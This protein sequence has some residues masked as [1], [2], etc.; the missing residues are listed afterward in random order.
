MKSTLKSRLT[1]LTLSC[2]CFLSACSTTGTTGTTAA[3]S[4]RST[5]SAAVSGKAVA[6]SSKRAIVQPTKPDDGALTSTNPMKGTNK[7]KQ[8]NCLTKEIKSESL[9]ELELS[10][11]GVTGNV[12]DPA[13]VALDMEATSSTG[14]KLTIPGFYYVP[15]SWTSDGHLGSQSGE[16]TWRLRFT[17]TLE[18]TWD[19]KI[20]LSLNGSVVDT[21][22]GYVNVA[23]S[24]DTRGVLKVEPAR[25]QNF[26][27]QDGESYVPIGENIGWA[28]PVND[29]SASAT[30]FNNILGKIADNGGNFARILLVNWNLAL[31]SG[32]TPPDD[33]SRGMGNAM[34]LDKIV[35]YL[36]QRN[37]YVSFCIYQHDQFHAEDN[38][39]RGNAFNAANNGY[40]TNPGDFFTNDRAKKDAKIYIRYIVARYGYSSN[41][42]TWELF[43]EIDG[44]DGAEA[45]ETTW[46]VEMTQYL[47]SIDSYKHLVSCSSAN[48]P[49]S[50]P[51]NSV[52][53]FIQYHR[54]NYGD[55]KNLADLQKKTWL[56]QQRPL[57]LGEVGI[58]TDGVNSLDKDLVN[59]HQQNWIGVMGGGAGACVNWFWEQLEE[60][61]GYKDYKPLSQFAARIPWTDPKMVMVDTANASPDNTQVQVLGYRGSGYA[62]LWVFDSKYTHTNKMVTDFPGVS[63]S[64][65]MDNGDYTVDWVDPWT[66]NSLGKSSVT[67]SDK[68]ANIKTPGWSKDIAVS[69]TKK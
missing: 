30:Y 44:T 26:V 19:L 41:I 68:K 16:G 48:Y 56:Q 24:S 32:Q 33:L 29:N 8:V 60:V 2:L 40:L 67:V 43:N 36:A 27:F 52:F 53:D 62:Y 12:Y 6:V 47:R 39:W 10:I 59:F 37:V 55:V 66:G 65:T 25:K 63:F 4:A 20:T 21:V 17:P 9:V 50:V 7:I 3:S 51:R 38:N 23:Q 1:V 45:A 69:I 57:M 46:C 22:T 42:M 28:V 61:D 31:I 35:E 15:Y 54:Y 34:M 13:K 64:L 11:S 5:A 49:Y 58:L 18:G 14:A